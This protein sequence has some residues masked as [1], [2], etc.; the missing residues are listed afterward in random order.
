MMAKPKGKMW[1][2]TRGQERWVAT[3]SIRPS[4][5]RSGFS[6]RADLL[7]GFAA[8]RESKTAHQ[9]YM[10]SY[11]DGRNA[12]DIR[13]ITDFADGVFDTKDGID[14]IYWVDPMAARKNVLNQGWAVPALA[15]ED[16]VPLVTDGN[17]YGRPSGVATPP[18][19]YGMPA[20]GAQYEITATSLSIEQYIPIPPG[21]AAWVGINGSAEAFGIIRVDSVVGYTVSDTFTP[22]ILDP[23]GAQRFTDQ[24]LAPG[25]VIRFENPPSPTTF[26]LYGI[27]VQILPIGEA[28]TGAD[29]ISGQGHSGCQFVGPRTRTP[30]SAAL[31]RTG[32]VFTLEETGMAL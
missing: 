16:G 12:D 26:T 23:A 7:N 21:H 17:G 14:L 2:G 25:I 27:M 29:F 3:P 9:T 20:R 4:Y 18:N 1:F 8:I 30:L 11:S 22:A 6:S 10:L 32:L 28:P 31:N 13:V 15:C 24:I 5:G 19:T